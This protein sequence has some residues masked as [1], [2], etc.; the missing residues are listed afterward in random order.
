[1]IYARL[2]SESENTLYVGCVPLV[3]KEVVFILAEG[4]RGFCP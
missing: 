4:V 3:A 1:M 2:R